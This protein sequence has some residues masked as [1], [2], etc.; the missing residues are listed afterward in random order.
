MLTSGQITE[1]VAQCMRDEVN[2][3][4]GEELDRI[5]DLADK[6]EQ[7]KST[8]QSGIEAMAEF[9]ASLSACRVG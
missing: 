8:D 7:G 6:A 9:E 2:T 1:S 3:Y 5:A 4:E